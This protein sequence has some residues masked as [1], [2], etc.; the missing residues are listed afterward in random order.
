MTEDLARSIDLVIGCTAQPLAGYHQQ[1]LFADTEA[2]AVRRA[3]PV[4]AGVRHLDAFLKVRHVAVVGRGQRED[5]VDTWLCQNGIE[6]QIGIV[7]PSYLQALH[8]VARTDLAAFLPRRLIEVLG[9]PLS[10]IAVSPPIDP[11]TYEEYMFHPARAHVDSGSIWLRNHALKI[12]LTLDRRT[13]GDIGHRLRNR[14]AGITPS[15][16]P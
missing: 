6:R 14:A 13:R 4:G 8:V 3:H 5:P 10:L 15:L 12:G 1:R 16:T 7:V 9:R 11:G 2:V